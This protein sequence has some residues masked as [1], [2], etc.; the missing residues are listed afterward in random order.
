MPETGRR[1]QKRAEGLS[2]GAGKRCYGK[3][4]GIDESEKAQSLTGPFLK[5]ALRLKNLT[6][7]AATR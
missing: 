4:F 1:P 2:G 6:C 5:L 3:S 7:L